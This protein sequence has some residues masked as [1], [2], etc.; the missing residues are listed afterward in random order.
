MEEYKSIKTV[1]SLD[2]EQRQEYYHSLE[3]LKRKKAELELEIEEKEREFQE[4]T[5]EAP[6]DRKVVEDAQ[7]DLNNNLN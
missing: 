3:A 7:K 6:I 5:G 4:K 2:E 1:K